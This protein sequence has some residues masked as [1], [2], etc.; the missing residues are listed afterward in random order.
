MSAFGL[1]PVPTGIN[2]VNSSC[3]INSTLQA[4]VE[5]PALF[6]AIRSRTTDV[7]VPQKKK[8]SMVY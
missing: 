6:D 8:K 2:N 3:W 7:S 4:I 5:C 1:R